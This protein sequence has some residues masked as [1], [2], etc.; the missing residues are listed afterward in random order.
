MTDDVFERFFAKVAIGDGC[1]HWRGSRKGSGYGAFRLNG[2]METAH[3]VAWLLAHGAI[4]SGTGY[5][6]T[7]VLHRCDNRLCVRPSH[8]F[9]GTNAENAADK[10]A[11]GRAYVAPGS[12]NARA[13]LTESDVVRIRERRRNGALLR[14]LAAD[15]GVSMAKISQ[16]ALG[17]CWRHVET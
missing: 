12:L 15:F 17:R 16:I 13:K 8:L 5:H 10:A 11:K 3:R 7:C 1:W 4:P 2:R 6:G 9:L 14:T